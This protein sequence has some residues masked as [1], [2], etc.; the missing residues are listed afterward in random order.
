[1][2]LVA[3]ILIMNARNLQFASFQKIVGVWL[4]AHTTQHGVYAVL[5]RIAFSVSYTSVLRLM[6]ALALSAKDVIRHKATMQGFLL[7]YDNINRMARAW[8][9]DVAGVQIF[10]IRY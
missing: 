2:V 4:F 8:D 5:S 6:R 10:R 7:I 3:Y 9:Q 1:M